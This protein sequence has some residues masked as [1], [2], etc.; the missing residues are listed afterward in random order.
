[1]RCS[2]CDYSQSAPSLYNQGLSNGHISRSVVHSKDHGYVCTD[3]LDAI[4]A[5]SY[6]SP[7]EEF[8]FEDVNDLP[9]DPI[10][11]LGPTD[12]VDTD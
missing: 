5:T 8:E 2:I 6:Y 7:D 4:T 3:C 12:E 11:E 1:M 9:E 10:E